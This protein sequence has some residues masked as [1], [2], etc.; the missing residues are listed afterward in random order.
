[1]HDL[2]V[3]MQNPDHFLFHLLPPERSTAN[4][5]RERGYNFGLY[6]YNYKFF[7]QSFVVNCLFKFLK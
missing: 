6:E 2:Y 5:L 7:R 1:M 4:L 3:K